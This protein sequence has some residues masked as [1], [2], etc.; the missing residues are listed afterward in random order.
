MHFLAFMLRGEWTVRWQTIF[1]DS[2]SNQ[3]T[4]RLQVFEKNDKVA[5]VHLD[6]LCTSMKVIRRIWYEPLFYGI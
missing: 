4:E 5:N 1:A 2:F 3:F 6:I